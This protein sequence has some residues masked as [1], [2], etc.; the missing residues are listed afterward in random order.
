MYGR[1]RYLPAVPSSLSTS[2]EPPPN[3]VEEP[4][5]RRSLS[6][7]RPFS[8]QRR[9]DSHRHGLPLPA[10]RK[11][12]AYVMLA[13]KVLA[14][15][16]LRARLSSDPSFRPTVF[17]HRMRS[18]SGV[19]VVKLCRAL[20]T[21]EYIDPTPEMGQV[22][23][24]A[25]FLE[26]L[27]E[28]LRFPIQ[29]SDLHAVQKSL[30]AIV[31]ISISRGIYLPIVANRLWILQR[32]TGETTLA[33]MFNPKVTWA[34]KDWSSDWHAYQR[35]ACHRLLSSMK[36]LLQLH[37]A[38]QLTMCLDNLCISVVSCS[39]NGLEEPSKAD[40]N[41]GAAK[42]RPILTHHLVL[43]ARVARLA[44]GLAGRA[45]LYLCCKGGRGRP[46]IE[47]IESVFGGRMTGFSLGSSGDRIYQACKRLHLGMV[48]TIRAQNPGRLGSSQS[49]PE[50]CCCS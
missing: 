27:G 14:D 16:Y 23:T 13:D 37:I 9:S 32:P 30:L 4:E 48:A 40:I 26:G 1:P 10:L 12:V 28:E 34:S 50:S 24:F 38:P 33:V 47:L 42:I 5:P 41:S 3:P 19:R 31:E 43:F 29:V 22:V 46:A 35:Y 25:R 2:S 45:A 44:P 15:P 49:H 18:I 39:F 8:K 17:E 6:H 7:S 21:I 36:F 20:R 11:C